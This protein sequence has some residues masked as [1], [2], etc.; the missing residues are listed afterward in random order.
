MN[1]FSCSKARHV[2]L[3]DGYDTVTV[4]GD[5]MCSNVTAKYCK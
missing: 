5:C 2:F 4:N 3:N 1:I